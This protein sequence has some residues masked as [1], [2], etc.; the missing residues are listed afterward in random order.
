MK[1]KIS[2]PHL[3]SNHRTPIVQPVTLTPFNPGYRGL[4]GERDL[5]KK[6]YTNFTGVIF[7]DNGE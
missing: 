2:S 4:H 1:R 7:C 3:E 5:E 6:K